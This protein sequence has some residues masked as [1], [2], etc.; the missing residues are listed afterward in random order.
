VIGVLRDKD[1]AAIAAALCGVVDRW[2]VCALPGERGDS[3]AQLAARLALP[4]GSFETAGSVEAGCE[5]ACAAAR[6]G[7]RVV[8]CGSVYTVGPAL[9]WLRLY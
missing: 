5:L 4:A 7:D 8:V 9:R 6:A 1:A 3:A 2:M